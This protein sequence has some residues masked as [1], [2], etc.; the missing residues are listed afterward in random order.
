MSKLRDKPLL[1]LDVNDYNFKV[2]VLPQDECLFQLFETQ[3]LE[4]K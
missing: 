3:L 1:L 2:N 4:R